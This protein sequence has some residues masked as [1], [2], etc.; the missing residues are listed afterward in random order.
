MTGKIIKGG[1]LG[2]AVVFVWTAISWMALPWHM[3]SFSTLTDETA[4]LKAVKKAAPATGLYLVPNPHPAG[5]AGTP[6]DH[7]AVEA[8]AVDLIKEGPSGMFMIRAEGHDP[9]DMKT[10][11][12]RAFLNQAA[13]AALFTWILLVGGAAGFW[14]R[15]SIVF[16]GGVA[17]AL[18]GHLPYW[19]WWGFPANYTCVMITET[20]IGWLLAGFALAWVTGPKPSGRKR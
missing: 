12:I 19:N 6:E 11:M 14:R 4:V 1:L 7:K 18:I 20:A 16:V 10:G 3:Q 9:M 13:V 17:G 8:R 5:A 2:G 15:V